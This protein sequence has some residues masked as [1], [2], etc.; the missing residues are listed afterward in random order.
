MADKIKIEKEFPHLVTQWDLKKNEGKLLSSYGKHS[1]YRAWWKC[2]T[3]SYSW[4][5][6]IRNRADRAAKCPICVK[7]P[8][9]LNSLAYRFPEIADMI[10]SDRN[11][12]SWANGKITGIDL[13]C[14]SR[15][16]IWWQCEKGHEF[17]REIKVQVFDVKYL[18]PTCKFDGQKKSKQ[19]IVGKY[20][21]TNQTLHDLT[22]EQYIQIL[23]YQDFK[24]WLSGLPIAYSAKRQKFI[25]TRVR[26]RY[27]K[28][29]LLLGYRLFKPPKDD[30]Y[31]DIEPIAPH[32]DH[33][34]DKGHIRAILNGFVNSFESMWI[35]L[36]YPEMLPDIED[37]KLGQLTVP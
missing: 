13:H 32:I 33:D 7:K 19:I 10:H 9:Y 1:K 4:Q 17:M 29:D 2:K 20:D 27:G 11:V 8:L 28:S 37:E 5:S 35:P 14:R 16:K 34:H 3:C 36:A 31:T 12:Y 23:E 6:A 21:I 25:D 18:C 22:P 26:E 24:C 30:E 15:H